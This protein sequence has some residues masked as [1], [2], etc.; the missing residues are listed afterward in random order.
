MLS[1]KFAT[2][3][4]ACLIRLC[5]F[6]VSVIIFDLP[7]GVLIREGIS[8]GADHIIIPQH[9][10]LPMVSFINIKFTEKTGNNN[11]M[12]IKGKELHRKL[13]YFYALGTYAKC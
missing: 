9:T 3:I 13:V 8:H 7:R 5:P 11:L 4:S 12:M 2:A 6:G 1:V 10:K